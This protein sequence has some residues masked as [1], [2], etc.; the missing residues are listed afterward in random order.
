MRQLVERGQ[1]VRASDIEI[2][3]QEG[4]LS[5]QSLVDLD[6]AIGKEAIRTLRPESVVRESDLRAP[7]QI[8]KGE[9]VSV[10][11]RTGGIAVGTRA[12][13]KQNGAMGDLISVETIADKPAD[14]QRLN[15]SVSGPGEATIF[16]TGI[17]TTDYASLNSD[18]RQRR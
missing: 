14:K 7:W 18:H 17:R 11:V 2:R 1:L 6:R 3:D 13:A 16:A 9:T 5:S 4:N 12:I 10:V 15:V 8:R